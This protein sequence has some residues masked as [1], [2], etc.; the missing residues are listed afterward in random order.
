MRAGHR[1]HGQ[2]RS[3]ATG[4]AL[5]AGEVMPVVCDPFKEAE[6]WAAV[7]RD[8]DVGESCLRVSLPRQRGRG[9]SLI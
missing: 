7:A 6:V 3:A 5:A 4:A 8:A 2:T 1:V 9:V